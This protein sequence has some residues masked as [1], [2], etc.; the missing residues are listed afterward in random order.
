M[1]Q[2]IKSYG[3]YVYWCWMACSSILGAMFV[4]VWQTLGFT[5]AIPNMVVWLLCTLGLLYPVVLHE[6]KWRK[7]RKE[8]LEK[9]GKGVI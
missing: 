4:V 5:L 6:R 2:R 9:G 3:S 8:K 1:W 7:K